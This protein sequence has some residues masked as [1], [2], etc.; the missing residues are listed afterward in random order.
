[1]GQGVPDSFFSTNEVQAGQVGV[2]MVQLWNPVELDG[3]PFPDFGS[4]AELGFPVPFHETGAHAFLGIAA[5]IDDV[6]GFEQLDERDEFFSFPQ[7]E[8][9]CFLHGF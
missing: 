1:M 7:L 5:G 8:Y 2:E 3:F 6:D 9:E 4:F